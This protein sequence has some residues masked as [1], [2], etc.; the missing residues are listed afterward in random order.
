MFNSSMGGIFVEVF[1]LYILKRIYFYRLEGDK[2]I[3]GVR[4]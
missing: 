3:M 1:Y 2:N 4:G